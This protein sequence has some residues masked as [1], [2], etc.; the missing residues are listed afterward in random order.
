MINTYKYFK[1]KI[2]ILLYMNI[3]FEYKA[4]SQPLALCLPCGLPYLITLR[5]P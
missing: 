4:P 3:L 5:T 2:I 1:I